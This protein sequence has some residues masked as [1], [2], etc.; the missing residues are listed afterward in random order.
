MKQSIRFMLI[1]VFVLSITIGTTTAALDAYLW[2]KG[3]VQGDIDGSV[4]KAGRE[5]SMAVYEMKHGVSSP[6]DPETGAATGVPQHH[7]MTITKQIDRATPLL[8]QV[9]VNE[10]NLPEV[11]LDLYRPGPGGIE[12]KFYTITLKNARVVDMNTYSLLNLDPEYA[13]YPY[14][15]EVSFVYQQITWTWVDGGI[16]ASDDWETV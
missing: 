3:E 11:N 2:V 9:L 14:L 6:T 1:L 5:G 15:E 4:T 13:S 12:Q 10:E 16:T 8:Y 7:V